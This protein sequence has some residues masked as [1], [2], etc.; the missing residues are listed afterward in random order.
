MHA[1]PTTFTRGAPGAPGPLAWWST[2]P[3]KP[4]PL[5]STSMSSA[6]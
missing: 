5:T 6:R 3:M 1:Q 4:K 2:A